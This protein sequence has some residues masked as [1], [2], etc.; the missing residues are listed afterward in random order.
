MTAHKVVDGVQVA[1]DGKVYGPGDPVD[2]VPAEL[3]AEWV[4]VG[5]VE[6]VKGKRRS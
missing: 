1:H 5:W 2:D 6:P 3:V 4:R